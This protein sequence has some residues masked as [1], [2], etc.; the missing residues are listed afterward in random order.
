MNATSRCAVT[1]FDHPDF[2]FFTASTPDPR[3]ED[4]AEASLERSESWLEPSRLTITRRDDSWFEV[5]LSAELD[6]D[7]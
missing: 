4:I 7:L 5:L 2:L 3:F 6:R 1:G